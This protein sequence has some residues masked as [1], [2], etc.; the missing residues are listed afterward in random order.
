MEL[1]LKYKII[2]YDFILYLNDIISITNRNED[3]ILRG[4]NCLVHNYNK[5]NIVC[6]KEAIIWYNIHGDYVMPKT[7]KEI[8][9]LCHLECIIN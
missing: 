7:Y 2:L 3:M 6:L 8:H 4:E 5:N 1:Y 9:D